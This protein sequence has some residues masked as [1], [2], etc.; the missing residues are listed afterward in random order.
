MFDVD[1]ILAIA[2]HLAVF[3]LIA[4]FATEFAL[5]RPGLSGKRLTQLVKI[6]AFYGL[7]AGTV[8]VVGLLRVFFGRTPWDYYAGNWVFWLKMVAFLGVGLASIR[9][10]I[11]LIRWNRAG[12][13]P[14]DADIL[15]LRRF[16]YIEAALFIFIPTF[17]AAMARGYGA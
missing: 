14:S 6:D 2:H 17:A 13:S 4:I 8:V 3:T 9:P 1:L 16:L 12:A 10:T 7:M 5:L 15:A 11:A